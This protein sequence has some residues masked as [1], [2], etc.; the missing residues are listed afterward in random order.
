M[1]VCVCVC[2]CDCI[3]TKYVY[4]REN[5]YCVC[6]EKTFVCVCF[7]ARVIVC[8]CVTVCVCVC[9]GVRGQPRR[10]LEP[11]VRCWCRHSGQGEQAEPTAAG[12]VMESAA[13]L[14]SPR[15][16]LLLL[17]WREGKQKGARQPKW[18]ESPLRQWWECVCNCSVCV[19]VTAVCVFV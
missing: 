6:E 10:P 19:C 3:C 13:D 17:T 7:C 15:P 14:S 1:Y 18:N 2:V 5:L 11:V 9:E 4:E 8:V 16:L 12:E